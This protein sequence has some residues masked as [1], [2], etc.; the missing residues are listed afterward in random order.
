M[1]TGLNVI[2]VVAAAYN[3]AVFVMLDRKRR[4][5]AEQAEFLRALWALELERVLEEGNDG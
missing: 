4:R 3:V 2:S 1:R 5:M